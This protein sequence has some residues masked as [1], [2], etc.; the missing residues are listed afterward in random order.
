MFF[1]VNGGLY[2]KPFSLT[3][4]TDLENAQICSTTD[5]SDPTEN[6]VLYNGSITIENRTSQPNDL[7]E[8]SGVSTSFYKAPNGLVFKGTV[9]KA[10][11][12]NAESKTPIF[13]NS[14]FVR[15]DI[16]D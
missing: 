1:S 13:V 4:S 16:F 5:G 10:R 8:I 7:S 3:L 6:S 9:I 2:Q 11:A 14:Y 15:D 12:V